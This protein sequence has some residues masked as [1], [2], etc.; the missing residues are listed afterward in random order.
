V[1]E[2]DRISELGRWRVQRFGELDSTNG[3]LLR[4]AADAHAAESGL[5]AVADHQTAGRGRFDRR[6]D[7]PPGSSL[8]VSVLV[9]VHSTDAAFAFVMAAGVAL[10][11]AVETTAGFVVGIKWP[12]DLVV[13]DRKLAGL[14]AERQGDSLVVGA[15]CNVNW[16][17]F[18]PELAV[19]ATACNVEAGRPI[20]RDSLLDAYLGA[21]TVRLDAPDAVPDAYRERLVT[22]GRRVRVERG[23][24]DDL[25]GEALG[26]NPDGSLRVLDDSGLEH[27]VFAGDVTHLRDA[28]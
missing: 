1:P 21:L 2:P 11:E 13:G 16:E 19:T 9:R 25:V 10:A 3:H 12:N 20:D 24:A 28:S 27:L 23:A 14:L 4:V 5:V 26:V 6:W 18:P 15:G 7:A 22:V 17:A 8:L